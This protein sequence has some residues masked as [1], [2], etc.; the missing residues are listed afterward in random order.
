MIYMQ[1]H[2]HNVYAPDINEDKANSSKSE[3][4][5]NSMRGENQYGEWGQVQDSFSMSLTYLDLL[6]EIK[7]TGT[8]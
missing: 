8:Q 7:Y 5:I 4:F 2:L 1:I 3:G 6:K